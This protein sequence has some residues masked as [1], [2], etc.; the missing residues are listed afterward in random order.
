MHF[1]NIIS[2]IYS[3]YI[4]ISYLFGI[5]ATKTLEIRIEVNEQTEAVDSSFFPFDLGPRLGD[6]RPSLVNYNHATLS[7]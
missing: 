5:L 3:F 1:R 6:P 7:G 4:I 2:K